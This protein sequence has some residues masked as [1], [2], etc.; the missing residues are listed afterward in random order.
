MTVDLPVLPPEEEAPARAFQPAE[1]FLAVGQGSWGDLEA[2]VGEHPVR[3]DIRLL[4]FGHQ[5]PAPFVE[6]DRERYA[7]GRLVDLR[8]AR[9]AP[10]ALHREHVDGV[11]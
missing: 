4:G 9:G 2:A 5:H 11:G 7:S 1:G 10:V 3:A 8:P 6:G